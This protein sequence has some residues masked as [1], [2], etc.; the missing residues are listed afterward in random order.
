MNA[1]TDLPEIPNQSQVP[2]S[3]DVISDVVCPWCFIG[4]RQLE[5][6]V[7]QWCRAHPEAPAPV[8]NW[9]PFQ[10]NP[11]MPLEG[12]SR[13]DYL[14][15]KFGHADGGKIYTNVQRAAREVGLELNIQGIQRQPNTLRPHALLKQAGEQGIQ[16]A[17]AEALFTAYFIDGR[18]LA[19][20]DEL[21]SI[22]AAAGL[23]TDRIARA[24]DDAIEH[25]AIAESDLQARENGIS[26]VPFFIL[27]RRVAVNGAAGAEHLLQAM[28]KAQQKRELRVD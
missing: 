20:P 25:E 19:A 24:L 2:M 11:D 10:L 21:S 17:L 26:G 9:L 23:D 15:R 22:A 12:V 3:I 5:Q 13:E 16:G 28:E 18:D 4:K 8:I 27:D 7:A 1:R 6:A 14:R